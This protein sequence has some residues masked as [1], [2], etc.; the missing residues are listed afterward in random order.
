[1]LLRDRP[2]SLSLA[3]FGYIWGGSERAR[4]C[5]KAAKH[6]GNARAAH[7]GK[8]IGKGLARLRRESNALADRL[9]RAV[10]L[11]ER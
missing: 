7:S 8:V 11:D 3:S 6:L 1:M 10:G 2:C 5:P 9:K 4:H